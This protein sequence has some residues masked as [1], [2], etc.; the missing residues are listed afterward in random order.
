MEKITIDGPKTP[1]GF[2]SSVWKGIEYVNTHPGVL[3]IPV[4]LD[5]F[6]WFGPHL[7][8]FTLVNPIIDSMTSSAI[9]NPAN[10]PMIEALKLA[11]EKFNL[12]SLLAFIPLVPPSLMSGAL[13][14]QTPLGNPLVLPLTNWLVVLLL[15]AGLIVCSLLIG[16]VYWVWA[17][18][19]ARAE[20]WSWRDALGR[21]ARTILM[22]FLMCT[23]F[24][25]LTLVFILPILFI[26]SMIALSAPEI[27]AILSQLF[28]FLGGGFVFWLI[29]FFMFSMHGTVL[30]RD[31][32][33]AAVWNSVN[34]SR[35]MYPVSIWI[36]LLLILLNFLTSSIWSLAPDD[37]WAGA[38]GV[39]GN[40]YTSSVVVVAS[41][42]YYIDKRRWIDEVRTYLETRMAGKTPPGAA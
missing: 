17:G 22:M 34:T 21:W 7:S 30:Y 11:A 2:F 20:P 10:V 18:G 25:M 29:L 32:V 8:I 4:L 15:A 36:P 39:L 35:W 19:A 42:A 16:S 9:S 41:M 3:V 14:D 38:V 31:G 13:P 33:T 27:G 6:L 5:A 28:F 26:I 23:A 12:F 24:F 1:I 40:A 37:S